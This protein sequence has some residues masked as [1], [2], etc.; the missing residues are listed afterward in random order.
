MKK[1]KNYDPE[2]TLFT[3]EFGLNDLMNYKR[4]VYKIKADLS[5]A[6]T[7]L[8]E[9][10]AKSIIVMLLPDVSRAPQFKNATAEL[11]EKLA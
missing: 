3:L 1:A 11:R 9:N 4:D 7:K 2:H 6:L 10:G 8:T 5:R